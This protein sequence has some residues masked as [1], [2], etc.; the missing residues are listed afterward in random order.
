MHLKQ[1]TAVDLIEIVGIPVRYDVIVDAKVDG[2]NE[3]VIGLVEL[4]PLECS[5]R[6]LI[7]RALVTIR[8]RTIPI[9]FI[10]S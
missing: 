7:A 3:S 6:H 8:N 2:R 1:K 4:N 5:Y 10:D 9:K